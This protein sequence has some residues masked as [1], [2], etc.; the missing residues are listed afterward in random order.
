MNRTSRMPSHNCQSLRRGWT[1]TCASRSPTD[2]EFTD[3]VAIF[4]L[5]DVPPTARMG[6]RRG[7]R[8]RRRNSHRRIILQRVRR[9]RRVV[10]QSQVALRARRRE[11]TK[12]VPC[13]PRGVGFTFNQHATRRER[14]SRV[15]TCTCTERR[16]GRRRRRAATGTRALALDDTGCGSR[17]WGRKCHCTTATST[18]RSTTTGKG[19]AS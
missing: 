17:G 3:E 16:R 7:R 5:F 12:H 11:H 6:R 15:S 4:D 18:T 9:A 13:Q 10:R 2:F 8:P 19:T 14:R 1:S